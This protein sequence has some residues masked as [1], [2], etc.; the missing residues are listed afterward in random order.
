VTPLRIGAAEHRAPPG[1]IRP[2]LFGQ[3]RQHPAAR[4]QVSGEAS[5]RGQVR[6]RSARDGH[7]I[8]QPADPA[9]HVKRGRGLEGE[10]GHPP[11]GQRYPAR[12]SAPDRVRGL[13]IRTGEFGRG[14]RPVTC[15]RQL[16]RQLVA[17]CLADGVGGGTRRRCQPGEQV[18]DFRRL[19]RERVRS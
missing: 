9:E 18:S 19:A 13:R 15:R 6:Q 1:G 10:D 12:G 17:D 7:R 2:V 4:G 11:A 14:E 16:Q 5:H 8:I 3:D